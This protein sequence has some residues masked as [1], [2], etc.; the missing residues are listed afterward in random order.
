MPPIVSLIHCFFECIVCCQPV[1]CV[2]VITFGA[3][4]AGK[5]KNRSA[6]GAPLAF[7]QGDGGE[8]GGV[9]GHGWCGELREV[10]SIGS[11]YGG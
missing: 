1:I 5:A 9:V 11:S 6:D 7:G 2:G 10:Y 3:L 8:S 4:I